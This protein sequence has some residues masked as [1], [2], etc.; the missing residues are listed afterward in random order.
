MPQ[1]M[2]RCET[3]RSAAARAAGVWLLYALIV[4]P[5]TVLAQDLSSPFGEPESS[6]PPPRKSLTPPEP[7]APFLAPM[8][9]QAR[10]EAPDQAGPGVPYPARPAG[11][12][13]IPQDGARGGLE[14]RDAGRPSPQ[15]SSQ[16]G[17]IKQAP[18]A[19]TYLPD[20]G[21]EGAPVAPVEKVDLDPVAAPEGSGLPYDDCDRR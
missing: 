11:P 9:G 10:D 18:A 3:H 5:G 12:Q 14:A 16:S 21:I 13:D 7:K 8:N 6:R 2:R 17:W 20:D 19:S 1:A 4:S 15:Q